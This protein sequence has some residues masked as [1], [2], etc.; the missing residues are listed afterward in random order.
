[1]TRISIVGGGIA[2]LTLAAALDPERFEV[3]VH[4]QRP[5]LPDAGTTL[6]MWPEART[7]LESI[8][9][10]DALRG[11]PGIERFPI[12]TTSGRRLLELSVPPGLLVSRGELLRAL[13]A[14]I[15]ASVRRM[16]GRVGDTSCDLAD[17]LVGADGVHSVV[18]ALIDPA[19]AHAHLTPYLAVRGVVPVEL[20]AS[21][22]GEHWGRGVL[23]G[24]SPQP[25]GTNWY[26]AFRSE[27]GPDRV[28]AAEA[29]ELAREKL[30]GARAAAIAP[31]LGAAEE[32]TTLAQRI[33]TVG[34]LRTFA[35]GRAVL[36]GDAAHAMC[37]NLGRGAC[38]S[39]V[40]AVTLA[41][42]LAEQPIEEALTAYDT[43]RRRPTQ[44]VQRRAETAMR[45]S[46]AERIQPIRDALAGATGRIVPAARPRPAFP[47]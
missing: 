38:E 9:A 7:A 47:A 31:V 34:R 27:L 23:F 37:P 5:D 45:I 6:A 29:L 13:D 40:D 1:M 21:D 22:Y 16:T 20:P 30:S 3:T 25:P 35:R 26:V 41:R 18:R 19:K 36:V 10:Y 4:E 24:T 28:D 2:G 8:G 46:L 12:L 42:L 33:W 17:V 39:I 15:P 43:A 11:M 14:A 32:T 44:Q